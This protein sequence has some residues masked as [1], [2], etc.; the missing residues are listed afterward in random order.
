V[1]LGSLLGDGGVYIRENGNPWFREQHCLEQT[2]YL[3]WK[4]SIIN[5]KVRTIDVTGVSGYTGAPQVGFQSGHSPAFVPYIGFK[6]TL[7]GIERLDAL[8]LAVWYMDDGCKGNGL[9]FSSESFTKEQNELLA[10]QL[11][12]KFNIKVETKNYA[13]NGKTYYYLSGGIEAKRR[14]VEVCLPFIQPTMAYKFDLQ[15]NRTKCKFCGNEVWFYGSGNRSQTCGKVVCQ[16]LKTGTLKK[17]II[18]GVTNSGIKW[19]YDFT[20]EGNHNFIANGLLNKNCLDE[21]DLAPEKPVEEARMIPS[22]G[23]NGELPITF[24][25]SSRKFKFGLV[26]KE[27]NKSTDPKSNIQVRHWNLLDV[28]KPCP[29]EK[30]LPN[31][32]KIPIFINEDKMESVSKEDFNILSD[33]EKNHYQEA[34]GYQGCLKNCSLFAACRGRLATKQAGTSKLLKPL[35]LITETFKSVSPETAQAQL[36]C[37]KPS[38]VGSIYPHFARSRHMKTANDMVEMVEGTSPHHPVNKAELIEVF[39]RRGWTFH[40]GMDFGFTHNFAA[41][42]AATDGWRVF[43]IDVMSVAGLELNE[44]VEACKAKYLALNPT[45]YPDPAYPSDIK[46]FK[47]NGFR[48][49]KFEK[50][51]LL[52]I[53]A[54]RTKL[55]PG[56]NREPE[57]FLLA[58][59]SGCDLLAK[60]LEVYHWKLDA[61]GEPTEEPDKADDDECFTEETEVL[62]N[63]GWISLKDV[64]AQDDVVSVTNQGEFAWEKP[65]I[66]NKTYSGILHKI[67]HVHLEFTAT[68]NHRHA[69]MT[70]SNWRVKHQF[71]LEKRSVSEMSGEMYWANSLQKWPV[72]KG[73]FE[74]GADEAW[75]AGFWLAEGCF[76]N[77]RPTYIIVDQT[78]LLQ[79]AQVRAIAAKLN[80]HYSE[81]INGKSIRFIFSG[82]GD[83]VS[84]WKGMF[85]E[86]SHLKRLTIQDVLS[87]TESERLA[88]WD[89]YMAGDGSRTKGNFHFDTVSKELADGMQ[90]LSLT[91]G[92]GCRIVSYNCMRAGRI[93]VNP[94][95]KEYT[96]RQSFRGHVLKKKPV[97]HINRKDF[98]D[99]TVKDLPV[100]CVRVSTG[101][102]LARTNG[103]VFVA[104]N[105]DALRY[106]CQNLFGK[107]GKLIVAGT[108]DAKKQR[109]ADPYSRE[110]WMG[111]KINE[112]TSNSGQ[113]PIKGKRGSFIFDV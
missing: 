90:F 94:Q 42:L 69:V 47:K 23:P 18:T 8:G 6:D 12:S 14:M 36:M 63:R 109:Y 4:R 110:N 60:R 61:A 84:K 101:Q 2:D 89:G 71:L 67:N 106:L 91:L 105:C 22:T 40:L 73:L 113:G 52:G 30:H 7:V 31:E 24:M 95:G 108:E 76:D 96:S 44:K 64:T 99:L 5:N 17:S 70:Q 49:K 112:L 50:M 20:V 75:M 56:M 53:D 45:V 88:L 93:I 16:Q 72:G 66:V 19:V 43:V 38:S 58:G 39:K 21:L 32:P 87:M 41:I 82:Q 29:P 111:T 11:N 98:V 1:V 107:S 104:G 28:S 81:T 85:R 54:V 25:I 74:Q 62:S 48:C 77:Y 100:Y 3:N 33:E 68:Q 102:F 15:G 83:R 80:W 10:A 9:R 65:E 57:M 13:K 79:Q 59:D 34:E 37:W 27:L 97:A 51:V 103:K 46:T 86:M 92:Y 55:M 35:P 78:K 26:Q